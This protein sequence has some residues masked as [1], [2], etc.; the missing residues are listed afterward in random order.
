MKEW[1]KK[2][3]ESMPPR[4]ANWIEP[5]VRGSE[6]FSLSLVEYSNRAACGNDYS[7]FATRFSFD[8]GGF[9]ETSHG[10]W[11]LSGLSL[12]QI[13]TSTG[14]IRRDR[15]FERP[16]Q[17]TCALPSSGSPSFVFLPLSVPQSG[18]NTNWNWWWVFCAEDQEC[19]WAK[20]GTLRFSKN[21][22]DSAAWRSGDQHAP[23]QSTHGG[24]ESGLQAEPVA[25]LVDHHPE[26]QVLQKSVTAGFQ[27]PDPEFSLGRRH[28]LCPSQ[29]YFLLYLHRHR[30][31]F[32]ASSWFF[33]GL[34]QE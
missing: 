6:K 17:C 24:D 15:T 11:S 22:S 19:L 23:D 33:D 4:K 30:S 27:A 18:K 14:E 34:W 29:G 5:K 20:Q 28:H 10:S 7:P 26:I 16:I 13:F 12:F 1:L 2:F 32:P 8:A 25:L 9:E 3:S 21:S 31:L